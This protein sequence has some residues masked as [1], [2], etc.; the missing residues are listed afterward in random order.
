MYREDLVYERLKPEEAIDIPLAE[1]DP[2][3]SDDT[4]CIATQNWGQTFIHRFNSSPSLYLFHPYS[5]IRR[6]AIVFTTHLYPL[7]LFF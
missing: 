6:A 7:S 1:M 4:F 5:A 3:V 2:K